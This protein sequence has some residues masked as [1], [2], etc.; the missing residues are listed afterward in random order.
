MYFSDACR[1]RASR[2]RNKRR[3]DLARIMREADERFYLKLYQDFHKETWVDELKKAQARIAEYE[4]RQRR[5]DDLLLG[6][7]E[8][9]KHLR[10]YI[11]A[12]EKQLAEKEAEIIRLNMLLEGPSKKKL[13]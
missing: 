5:R 4:K 6:I 10:D 9:Q 8:D 13:H 12:L 1:Q 11:D 3:H 2:A 7:L